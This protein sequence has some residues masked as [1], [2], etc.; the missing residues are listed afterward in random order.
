MSAALERG[1]R[2]VLPDEDGDPRLYWIPRASTAAVLDAAKRHGGAG[3]GRRASSDEKQLRGLWR[4]TGQAAEKAVR[5]PGVGRPENRFCTEKISSKGEH[6]D[7][8][9]KPTARVRSAHPG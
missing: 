1:D 3:R 5:C 6:G 7:A 4:R 2:E 8:S 9:R